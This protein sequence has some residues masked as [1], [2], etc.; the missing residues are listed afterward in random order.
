MLVRI[1]S[2]GN[3]HILLRNGTMTLENSIVISYK[4]KHTPL[5]D[6]KILLLH[7][8]ENKPMSIKNVCKNT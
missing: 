3:S 1:W 6:P 2:N 7:N 8:K 5:Y 4:A